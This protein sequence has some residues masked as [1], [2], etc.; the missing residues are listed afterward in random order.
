M[1]DTFTASAVVN[2][3]PVYL[4]CNIMD[5]GSEA[6][7]KVSQC[8]MFHADPDGN[9]TGVPFTAKLHETFP[10]HKITNQGPLQGPLAIMSLSG[11]S[12]LLGSS[13]FVTPLGQMQ[14][15]LEFLCTD[16]NYPA[17]HNLDKINAICNAYR[18]RE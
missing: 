7:K 18:H 6:S 3:T 12:A 2:D 5:R 14:V 10:V 4:S 13:D 1:A 11:S 9:S 16:A 17:Y 15:A 8:Q